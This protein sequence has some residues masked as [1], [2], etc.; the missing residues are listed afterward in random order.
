MKN[1]FRKK[2]S[3]LVVFMIGIMWLYM[4]SFLAVTDLDIVSDTEI[5]V[6]AA[7]QWAKSRNATDNFI[8]LAEDYWKLSKEHGNVNPAIA[9]AQAAVE[10]NFGQFTGKVTEDYCNPCG[11]KTSDGTKFN[12]FNSWNDGISAQLDHLALYAGAEGY[13]RDD[14]EDTRHFKYLLGLSKTI[15]TLGVLWAESEDYG[16]SIIKFYDAMKSY[17]KEDIIKISSSNKINK[18]NNKISG[19]IYSQ[20]KISSIKILVDDKQ[21]CALSKLYPS[22]DSNYSD[23]LNKDSY[24]SFSLDYNNYSG[25]HKIKIKVI[26]EYGNNSEYTYDAYI[27]PDNKQNDSNKDLKTLAALDNPRSNDDFNGNKVTIRGWAVSGDGIN[28]I[29]IYL[30]GNLVKTIKTGLSRPDV[31]RAYPAYNDDKCGYSTEINLEDYLEKRVIKIIAYGNNG[32]VDT[33]TRRFS[34]EDYPNRI[35]ID[36]PNVEA[37]S[38]NSTKILKVRGWALSSKK[39][40]SVDVLFNGNRYT[41]IDY[42]KSRPDVNRVFPQ[43]KNSYAGFEGNIE[44]DNILAGN[45]TIT[46]RVNLENGSSFSSSKN[47]RIDKKPFRLCLDNP[48]DGSRVDGNVLTVRGWAL[49]DSGIQEVKVYVN[50]VLKGNAVYGSNRPDV[51]RVFPGYNV[52][53]NSGYN[54]TVN[55]GNLNSGIHKVKVV[56]IAKD[57]SQ[58][59]VTK[60]FKRGNVKSKLI[61]VDAGHGG[62]DSGAPSYFNNRTYLEKDINLSVAKKLKAKLE[63]KGFEVVMTRNTDVFVDLVPR[64]DRANNLDADFFVSIHQDSFDN[65]NAK[66]TT[67]YYTTKVPD[68]GYWA[69]DK[70]YKFSKSREVAKKVVNNICSSIGTYSR[71]VI[72][73]SLSVTRNTD[74]PSI[75]VECGF[76]SNYS[77]CMIISSNNGQDKIAAAIANAIDNSF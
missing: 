32:S 53:D 4:P 2:I 62:Y 49:A 71:G 74:M 28:K 76:I 72:D 5:T 15:S 19:Y 38:T 24:F 18:D 46:V 37:L 6:K 65:P 13:P 31:K 7:Q 20:N 14:T 25:K 60:S 29:E 50:N 48:A 8:S 57:G 17:V 77:D 56:A 64:S 55:I 9:Y 10:T 52:G 41:S 1:K 54:L 35:T 23:Y 11:M 63:D 16:N 44:L 68:K 30:D 39:V 47:I 51:N 66:G 61:V 34:L 70:N 36:E 67:A 27:T 26:H 45:R 22:N 21:V 12:K 3:F 40:K 42:G 73:Q 69:K 33:A 43:Y 59:S 58:T 75:L